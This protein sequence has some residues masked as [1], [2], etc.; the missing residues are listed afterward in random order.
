VLQN[1]CAKAPCHGVGGS[2]G[3]WTMGDADYATL[4]AASGT[5]GQVIQAGN[6][7]ASNLYLKTTSNPPFGSRMPA[8]GPP[9][10]SLEDQE[11]I[12]DWIDQGAQDN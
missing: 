5:N 11:K 1:S 4:L 3:G 7:A 12:K 10:L 9:F 6:A 8:D 2:A